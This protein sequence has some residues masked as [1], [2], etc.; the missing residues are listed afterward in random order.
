MT[1]LKLLP[2]GSG[3]EGALDQVERLLAIINE[4]P[5]PEDRGYCDQCGHRL[6]LVKVTVKMANGELYP[7][8]R[9]RH[10]RCHY[11]KIQEELGLLK[12]QS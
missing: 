9:W 3:K 1:N 5:D 10:T 7:A 2:T 8:Y 4:V 11:A 12:D 6:E